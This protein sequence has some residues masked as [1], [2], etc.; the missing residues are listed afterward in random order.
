MSLLATLRAKK[1]IREV[2]TL[3]V[4][5]DATHE[6]TNAPTVAS[7]AT[8]TV[9]SP[10]IAETA[11]DREL[12]VVVTVSDTDRWCWPHSPAMN[13]GEIDAFT[14]RL[15]R[16]TDKGPSYNEAERLANAL[17]IRDRDGD[18]RRLCL[19]CPL[20][21]GFGR[22]RC[23]NWQAAGVARQE[24]ARDLV[25]TLQRCGGFDER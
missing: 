9:A 1:L 21:Q 6:R 3:T 5:T 24:L 4:A 7:V 18:D 11:N 2:V 22:W 23:G 8:V 17:V 19:E 14:P 13:N 12:T 16:F 15:A 10:E 25:L 20:L